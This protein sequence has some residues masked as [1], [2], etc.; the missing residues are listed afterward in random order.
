MMHCANP[1]I[2]DLPGLAIEC[3]QSNDG[4]HVVQYW[5]TQV[6]RIVYYEGSWMT[7]YKLTNQE[8]GTWALWKP[9]EPPPDDRELEI[10]LESFDLTDHHHNAYF[11]SNW[12]R[13]DAFV[14]LVAVLGVGFRE[15][16]FLR[17]LRAFRPFR[18]MVRF[19]KIKVVL[20][21]LLRAI[22]GI[23]HTIL[24]C[25]LFW[26]VLSILGVNQFCGLYSHCQIEN[27][28]IYSNPDPNTGW[29][30]C[31]EIGNNGNYGND[32]YSQNG[33]YFGSTLDTD[34][35]MVQYDNSCDFC[36]DKCI[37]YNFGKMECETYPGLVWWTTIL[38]FDNAL[39]AL[40]TLFCMASLSGWNYVMYEAIDSTEYNQALKEDNKP[41]AALYFM[42]VVVLCAFFSLNLIVSV[43][44]DKF[45]EIKAEKDG[46]AFQTE[47]QSLWFNN[48]RN[49]NRIQ[50]TPTYPTPKQWFRRFSFCVV[51]QSWF[52]PFIML[53]I[54]A[55]AV[56]MAMEHYDQSARFTQILKV[57]DYCFV[58][59]FAVEAVM[60]IAG[61]GFKPYI[62]QNW[63]KFDFVISIAGVVGLLTNRL[64]G[65]SVL[66]IFR[67][68]RLFRLLHK[69]DTL[70]AL[71]WIL[72]YSIPSV[73]NIGL[74]LFV[75]L[76]IY[77]VV[78]MHILTLYTPEYH[79]DVNADNFVN[80]M[81]ML[82]RVGTEDGWTDL[83]ISYLRAWPP[84]QRYMI[85]I[86]FISFFVVGT[87]VAINLFIAVVLDSFSE[88]EELF[89]R[90]DKFRIIRI[91]RDIWSYFDPDATKEIAVSDFIDILRLTPRSPAFFEKHG[92]IGPGFHPGNPFH[93][94][95]D[96]VQNE[97]RL[98]AST[99][100]LRLFFNGRLRSDSSRN[101]SDRTSSPMEEE[102]P[103]AQQQGVT[104]NVY[105]R[106]N[107]LLDVE[108]RRERLQEMC[109]DV[110]HSDMIQLLLKLRLRVWKRDDNVDH[111]NCCARITKWILDVLKS[112][113]IRS[114]AGENIVRANT[115][116]KASNQNEKEKSL[117]AELEELRREIENENGNTFDAAKWFVS[118]DE[119]LLAMCSE[120]IGPPL[121]DSFDLFAID[122]PEIEL[123]IAEWYM[124]QNDCYEVFKEVVLAMEQVKQYSNVMPTGHVSI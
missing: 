14:V 12:N 39:Q 43:V 96:I 45:N 5:G 48:Q 122:N 65:L 102:E 44:V 124:I 85:Y 56:T 21:A 4:Y 24:F 35:N 17:A 40:H 123:R 62:M 23:V 46:S 29:M 10:V 41:E 18:I 93:A 52:D 2:L 63:N 42:L 7:C 30:G 115:T 119:A 91:W 15:I 11:A 113:G 75:I 83:Y 112:M 105:Q 94:L 66:R 101:V 57:A 67:V 36:D 33:T 6:L 61:F 100:T 28:V 81:A 20:A 19:K 72:M 84:N 26:L 13:L 27:D 77:A 78:A 97:Q 70:N 104:G 25:I 3:V 16:S 8:K 79:E 51:G 92:I 32:I 47:E 60:K 1:D 54:M 73:W 80:A 114:S 31:A 117:E 110:H 111:L 116:R 118:Y 68:A 74:L 55:N 90:E 107:V 88:N 109:P 71:F 50:L 58:S 38:N 89:S 99:S 37:R 69:M 121:P 59:I 9:G 98:N 49:L 53:C 103:S 64:P 82:Y 76:F 22:P 34:F 120:V 106:L 86:Y 95:L 87:L 108:E